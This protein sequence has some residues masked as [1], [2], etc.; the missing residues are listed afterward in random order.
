MT[1]DPQIKTRFVNALNSKFEEKSNKK[2]DITGDYTQDNTSYATVQA[3]KSFIGS[4]IA[5]LHAVATSGDYSDL[6]NTPVFNIVKQATAETGYAS[7]Y[8]LTIDETQVGAKIN[9]E[10]DKMLRSISV[11]T[12]GATPT[13]EETA[14]GLTT[15]DKYILMVVNTVDNDGTTHVILPI[16]DV[17]D[18]QTADEST[19]TLSANGV[20]SIKAGGVTSTQL[21]SNSV[22]TAKI[23]DGNVTTAK[24]DAKAVTKAKLADEVS[25]QWTADADSEIEAYLTAITNE[26][27]GN[28]S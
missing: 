5:G 7:T 10:K 24:L 4:V 25:A 14:A 22:T 28:N 11:E 3:I 16:N 23:V 17:F 27:N 19:L 1:V 12:V 26:L 2:N 13:A 15:G 8:Y 21:A 18:L 20:F 9:I 6:E